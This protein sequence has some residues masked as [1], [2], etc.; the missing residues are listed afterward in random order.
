MQALNRRE[1][2]AAKRQHQVPC[3]RVSAAG[4]ASTAAGLVGARLAGLAQV[5]FDSVGLGLG[6]S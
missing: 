5:A 6:W 2:E 3:F 4:G 1:S